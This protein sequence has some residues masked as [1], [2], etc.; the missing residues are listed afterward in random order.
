MTVA[1]NI[2]LVA[3]F[4][5]GRRRPISWTS[6]RRQAAEILALVGG[7]IDPDTRV[8]DLPRTERSLLAIARGLMGSPKVLV[9][10]EPSASL[11]AEDTA[12]LFEVVRQLQADG[13]GIIYISHRLNEIYAIAD[14]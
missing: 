14:S 11:P 10:D 12:R 6:T 13:V 7:G 5:G 9:L 3:G 2:A 4:P 1:E 8:F